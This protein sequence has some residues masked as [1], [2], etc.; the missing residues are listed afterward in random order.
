MT[1]NHEIMK[2]R[3]HETKT[4][5][6]QAKEIF[7]KTSYNKITTGW[8]LI[9]I[10]VLIFFSAGNALAKP[11]KVAIVPFKVNAEK[12]LSYLRNGIED[13]LSS[14]LYWENKVEVINRQAVEKA[15][16]S[17]AGTMN[18]SKARKLGKELG[19]DYVLF[20]SLTVFGNSVSID[21]KMVD[22]TGKKQPLTFFNQSQGMDQV[23]PSVNR[24]ASDIND[25]EFG[26]VM[27]TWR[28][29]QSPPAP[30]P[31]TAQ[32][33]PEFRQNPN[34]LISGGFGGEAMRNA[35]KGAPGSGFIA[36][37]TASA[38]GAQ[39]WKSR[40]FK[41][42]I[43]AIAIGDIDGDGKNETV[44]ATDH[45]LEA[46]RYEN[47]R[48]RKIGTLAKR[49]LDHLISVDVADINRNG[50]AEI[51]VSAL[52]P[53][54][55]YLK[56]F[57]L[58]YNGKTF[59]QIVPE[60]DWY[61]RVVNIP[62]R[63]HVLLGQKQGLD[64]PWNKPIFELVWQNSRYEPAN[65]VMPARRANVLGFCLGDVM[66]DGSE[67]AVAFNDLD[68]LKVYSST[69][70]TIWTDGEKSGGRLA[71]F[72]LPDNGNVETKNYAYYP[73]RIVI[74]DFN[75]DG[76]NDVITTKNQRLSNLISYRVFTHGEI[77]IRSWDGIGLA[78][79]WHTRKLSGYFS[80]FGIGDFDND[81]KDE[82]VASLVINT[83]SVVFTEPKSTIIAYKLEK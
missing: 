3:K 75:K 16:A 26:R 1:N 11:L 46:Y 34:K 80:D 72:E 64:S 83:G 58:E 28:A 48:F 77:E 49:D 53:F 41:L 47:K 2:N 44:F 82:L 71:S 19:A 12:D 10:F 45:T 31:K 43:T 6:I 7:L 56:S 61:Y 74:K 70:K 33:E 73:E 66:N 76:K 30:A 14:R 22:V 36:N 38:Q 13:M 68:N 79:L 78:T 9:L 51:F 32:T 18:E 60:S 8:T 25:K 37:Q 67:A 4:I 15:A 63:G 5:T 55:K 42:D 35:P 23:I 57:V 17:V 54:R 52:D 50:V 20:G 24:F 21:A 29:P 40:N 69:G 81:G 59:T 39:F 27:E 62:K 65:Q